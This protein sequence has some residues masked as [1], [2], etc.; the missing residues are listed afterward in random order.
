MHFIYV[1][2]IS[3]LGMVLDYAVVKHTMQYINKQ[4]YKP[5][6]SYQVKTLRFRKKIPHLHKS[7]VN[8]S[9]SWVFQNVSEEVELQK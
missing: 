6:V 8:S 2:F 3:K 4:K 5:R 9:G 1:P 7:L